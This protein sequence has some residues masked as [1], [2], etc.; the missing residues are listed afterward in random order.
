M[1]KIID[2]ENIKSSLEIIGYE[3]SDIIERKNNGFNWQIKFSNSG[4]IV[5]VYDTNTKKNSVVNGKYDENENIVLKDL[6]DGIKCK[7]YT[8][9]PLNETIV[10]LIN[11]KK[12]SSYY[13]FKREWYTKGKDGD[14]LHDILCLANNLDNKDSYL[15]IGVSDDYEVVGVEQWKKSNDIIDFLKSKKFAGDHL[16]EIEFHKL[17]YKHKK[18]DVLAIK[19]SKNVPFYITEKYKSVCP[20][21]IYTRTG[22]TNTPINSSASFSDTEKLWRVHFE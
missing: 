13:D 4:A 18:I 3:I 11:S 21:H 7:E 16:P 17:Y 15:I 12:E 8:V 14:L 2:I 22:D 20:F 10:S 9:D 19:N 6:V 1:A 5:T